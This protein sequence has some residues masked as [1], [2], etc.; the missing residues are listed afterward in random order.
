MLSAHMTAGSL[1]ADPMPLVHPALHL[2]CLSC[3]LQL[4]E[5]SLYQYQ[6]QLL[7][8]AVEDGSRALAEG[9]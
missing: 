7:R 1:L 3:L 8:C 2:L 5:R 6:V 9:G 4:A